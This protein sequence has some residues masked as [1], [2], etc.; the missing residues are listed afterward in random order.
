MTITKICNNKG[1]IVHNDDGS[2]TLFSYE[3]EIATINNGVCTIKNEDK[4]SCT[5]SRHIT[6]FCRFFNVKRPNYKISR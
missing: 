4:I 6:E 5:T 2:K 3:T 1:T